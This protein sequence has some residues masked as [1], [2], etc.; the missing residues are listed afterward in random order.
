MAERYIT[1]AEVSDIMNNLDQLEAFKCLG[2]MSDYAE[3]YEKQLALR[4]RWRETH[5]S[6]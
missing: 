6:N 4:Y 2:R 1:T 3:R 5:D